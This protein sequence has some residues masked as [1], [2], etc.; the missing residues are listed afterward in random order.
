MCNFLQL[1]TIR[2]FNNIDPRRFQLLALF[3]IIIMIIII[4][5]ITTTII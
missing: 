2:S 5:I 4:I 1:H 3:T